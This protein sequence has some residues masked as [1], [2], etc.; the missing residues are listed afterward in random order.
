MHLKA[1]AAYK[2]NSVLSFTPISLQSQNTSAVLNLQPE[3]AQ[4]SLPFEFVQKR[5]EAKSTK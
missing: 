5:Q 3:T 1:L 2:I 4:M